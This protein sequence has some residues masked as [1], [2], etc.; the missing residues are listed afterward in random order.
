MA[1]VMQAATH[2]DHQMK[3]AITEMD[4]TTS[5]LVY[6]FKQKFSVKCFHEVFVTV[7]MAKGHAIVGSFYNAMC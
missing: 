6:D 7:I 3:Q 5:C 2:Q 4:F 1:H